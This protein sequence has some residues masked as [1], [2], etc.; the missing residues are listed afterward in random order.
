MHESR[1]SKCERNGEPKRARNTCPGCQTLQACIA[2]F[3]QA[4]GVRSTLSLDVYIYMVSDPLRLDAATYVY[5]YMY[6]SAIEVV[7]FRGCLAQCSRSVQLLVW[8]LRRA[9]GDIYIYIYIYIYMYISI[10]L[11]YMYGILHLWMFACQTV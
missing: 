11:I 10:P 9:P 7:M 2:S 6:H 4:I 5:M 8:M 1:T 3:L